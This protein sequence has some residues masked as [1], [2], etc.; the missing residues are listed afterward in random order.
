MSLRNMLIQAIR[1]FAFKHRKWLPE[2]RRYRILSALG[3][4]AALVIAALWLLPLPERVNAEYSVTVYSHEGVL[5]RPY[6]AEGDVWRLPVVMEE[7]PPVFMPSLLAREDKRFYDHFGID[8]LA[9]ARALLQNLQSHQVIS[10][11]STITMQL[12]RLLEPRP[13]TFTSKLIESFRALQLELQLSKQEILRLY[14]SY[15][16]YGGNVEGISAASYMYFGHQPSE[17]T[18]GEMAMLL[19]LP[20]SPS[21]WYRLSEAQWQ[22]AR[23]R[24]LAE[25]QAKGVI[26]KQQ[27]A[28]GNAEAIPR[29]RFKMPMTAPHYADY[30][31]QK[32]PEQKILKTTLSIDVQR[33]AEAVVSRIRPEYKALGIHNVSVLVVENSSRK[34][35]AAVGNFGYLD[36]EQGQ[37][38][39]SFDVARS[40]GS[41][42]KPFLYAMAIEQGKILPQTLLLDVPTQYASYEP[43]NFSGDYKGLVKAEYALSQSLNIPFVRMLQEIGLE[44]F[45]AFMEEGVS[46]QFD[47]KQELGLSMIIGG[48]ELTPMQLVELYVNLASRGQAAP[49]QLLEGKELEQRPWFSEGAMTL[50]EQALA[51]RDRPDFPLRKAFSRFRPDVRWKTGTS[52]GRRDAWSIGYDSEY[53]VLV[54]FGNLDQK[55]SQFLT[56]A[57]AA[58]PVMFELLEGLQQQRGSQAARQEWSSELQQ[59]EVCAFSGETP[60]SSCPE[61]KTV[62]GLK[63][64]PLSGSCRFHQHV[65][66]D[67][68]SGLR[69]LKGCDAE[70]Q[71]VEAN[72]L[73]LPPLVRRWFGERQG[74]SLT[75]PTFHPGCKKFATAEGTLSIRRPKQGDEYMLLPSFG[76]NDVVIRMDIESSSSLQEASCFLNGRQMADISVSSHL[77]LNLP[78]GDYHIF[79][80]NI[81]GGSDEVS[82]K[83]K[84]VAY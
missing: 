7:L 42:L 64:Y 12:V 22:T 13:R 58:A 60:S 79:C 37:S 65:L 81:H 72:V 21:R 5:L 29:Q 82:F 40:P 45:L 59:V 52:Q 67:K 28:A 80:S 38:F 32:Q 76:R 30:V 15:A 39:N 33:L 74:M 34:V 10:G 1:K 69:V 71:T 56:G 20:Q 61:T 6:L 73:H 41:T 70:M 44:H 53:T 77:T 27:Q 62:M 2:Q 17:I 26:S 51:M 14:L 19:L 35:R 75:V 23:A 54:W 3:A 16:P 43:G 63:K 50:L 78:R 25:L 66:L 48:V 4:A 36:R 46:W 83:V 68:A 49:L 84:D 18:A 55:P 57:S 24:V 8:P 47:R 11:G 31:K 9:I